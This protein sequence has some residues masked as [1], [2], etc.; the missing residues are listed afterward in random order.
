MKK[1]IVVVILLMGL[2]SIAS[3]ANADGEEHCFCTALGCWGCCTP[4]CF[5]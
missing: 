3:I 2:L 5:D 4:E 1:S